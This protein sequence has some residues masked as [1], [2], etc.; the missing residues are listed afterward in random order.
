MKVIV[1]GGAGYIGSVLVPKLLDSEFTYVSKVIVVDNFIYGQNS[2]SHCCYHPKFEAV[3]ADVRDFEAIKWALMDADVVVPLAAVVGAPACDQNPVDAQLIN[4]EHP[5]RLF[6]WL[7]QD[8]KVI[9]PTTESAYGS[10]DSGECS[11]G[12]PINPLSTYAKDK[13]RIETALMHRR[14]AVSLRFATVFG[15]SPRMRLDLLINDFVWKAAKEGTIVIYEGHYKRTCLHVR[16]AAQAIIHALELPDDIYNVGAF[17]ASKLEICEAINKQVKFN[18]VEMDS[19]SDPD[20]RNYSVS[21][22]KLMKH[23]FDFGFDLNLGITELLKGYKM[24]KN[25]RYGNV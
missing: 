24:L 6:K 8:Q 20:Q 22:K 1:L 12:T 18:Y 15:M 4:V 10:N 16:D 19:G 13:A 7:S 5:L 25:T 17:S 11:E 14:N 3:K 2:L 9:M 23:G 21:S